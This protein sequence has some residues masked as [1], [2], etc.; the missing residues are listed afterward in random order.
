MARGSR[1]ILMGS[2]VSPGRMTAG[3]LTPR[4]PHNQRTVNFSIPRSGS[5]MAYGKTSSRG[6]PIGS[7]IG[8]PRERGSSPKSDGSSPN[9]AGS[10]PTNQSSTFPRSGNLME[11]HDIEEEENEDEADVD[12]VETPV[13]NAQGD[14]LAKKRVK[15]VSTSHKSR[16]FRRAPFWG[17]C[18]E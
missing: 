12:L 11:L 1:I 3:T 2:P 6:S 9:S 7:P 5:F 10:S 16:S 14:V 8:S 13:F 4:S 17:C 15:S 18:S